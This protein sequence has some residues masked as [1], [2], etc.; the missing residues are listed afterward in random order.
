MNLEHNDAVNSVKIHTM[1]NIYLKQKKNN[2]NQ[3]CTRYL[4]FI[5]YQFYFI[6]HNFKKLRLKLHTTKQNNNSEFRKLRGRWVPQILTNKHK[7]KR[8]I[9]AIDFLLR[10]NKGGEDFLTRIVTGDEKSTIPQKPRRRVNS[11]RRIEEDRQRKRRWSA[12]LGR[13]C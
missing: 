10:Y 4:L 13:S 12:Q 6:R 5:K 2:N 8:A 3:F 11:G 9:A 1:S 7:S